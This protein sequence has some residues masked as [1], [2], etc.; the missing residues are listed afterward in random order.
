MAQI[1]ATFAELCRER[2]GTSFLD[3]GSIYGYQWQKSAIPADMPREYATA[4]GGTF[5]YVSISTA[6]LL[7]ETFTI[8]QRA[9]RAFRRWAEMG[10]NKDRNWLD[11][12]RE[13]VERMT[14]RGKVGNNA[15]GL[16]TINTYNYDNELDQIVQIVS[17]GQYADWHLI[18]A[19]TG[20]DARGGYT[21]PVVATGDLDE[22]LC[23]DRVEFYCSECERTGDWTQAETP[24]IAESKGWRY[25]VNKRSVTARCPK[26][27]NAIR[28]PL[29]SEIE[30][31]K[32]S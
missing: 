7:E 26:G 11:L 29:L 21:A 5:D 15:D 8:D 24:T 27:H 4:Y 13:Y 6:V 22:F 32:A 2:S 30:E 12:A 23:S 25:R 3:S 20:C 18:Q 17:P 19:H 28:F 31:K 9:T 10:R 14:E 1:P 16:M